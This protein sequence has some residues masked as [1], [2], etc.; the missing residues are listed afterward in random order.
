MY[1][2]KIKL[3]EHIR[4]YCL[5]NITDAGYRNRKI[6]DFKVTIS[7]EEDQRDIG[8]GGGGSYDEIKIHCTTTTPKRDIRVEERVWIY[9]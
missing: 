3:Q 5:D 2:D 4:Q 7:E 6:V 1:I 8:C 9:P